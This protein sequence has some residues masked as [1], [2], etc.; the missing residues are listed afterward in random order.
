MRPCRLIMSTSLLV[1]Q[2]RYK[3]VVMTDRTVP[4]EVAVKLQVAVFLYW[5]TVLFR[6]RTFKHSFSGCF[7]SST[8]FQVLCKQ[9]GRLH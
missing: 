1:G 7:D 9:F 2:V 5:Y 3:A 6:S 4:Q 8:S